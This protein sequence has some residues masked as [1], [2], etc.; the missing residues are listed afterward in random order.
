MTFLLE[1]GQGNIMSSN[2]F[3]PFLENNSITLS[4]PSDFLNYK[5]I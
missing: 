5:S 4:F 1:C 3:L 2:V